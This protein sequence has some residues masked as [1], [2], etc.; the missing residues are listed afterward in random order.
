MNYHLAAPPLKATFQR[1]AGGYTGNV[2]TYFDGA[3]GY[4]SSTYLR[5][6][7]DDSKRS[8]LRFDVSS[9]P[10]TDTIDIATLRMY[11][12]SP[13]NANG[14][15]LAADGVLAAWT[16]SQTNRVQR[17][18]GVNWQVA[19]MGS[20][21]D[22][23]TAADGTVELTSVNN[24]WVDVDVTDMVQAWIA[25]AGANHG[26]VLL[27]QA[28]TGSVTYSFCSELGWSPCTAAQAPILKV[29]H[30]QPPP[31]IPEPT[32]EPEP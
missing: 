13:S 8:L 15:T 29:W 1:G 18:T 6:S 28:A 11:Q 3:A 26:L 12:A 32:P 21:G 4:N 31:P 24:G 22:Y 16:D 14:L 2:A 20:G 10:I 19:G 9:I 23:A 5:V 17:Q 27:A 30:H 7:A 25:D